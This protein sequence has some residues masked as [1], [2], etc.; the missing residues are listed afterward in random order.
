MSAGIAVLVG[1]GLR[2][3]RRVGVLATSIVLVLAAIAIAAGLVVSRQGAPLLDEAADEANVA[4]LVLYGDPVAITA[5]AADPAVTAWSGPFAAQGGIELVR[6]GETVPIEATALDSPDIAVNRPPARAG[7]WAASADEIV[8]DHSV[9]DDLGIGVGER[10]TLRHTGRDVEFAVVGTAVNFTDC[11]YPQCE[12]GRTWVTAAGLDRFDASDGGYAVGYLRFADPAAADPFVERQ[13]AAGIGGITGTDSWL[14]TRGDFLVLDRVFGSFVAAFGV[15]V[16]IVAAVVIAGSTAMR[17]VSQR[18]AIALLGAIGATPRQITAALLAENLVIG[19][20]AAV[21]GWFVAG[22][23]ASSLQ[24]GIGRTLGPQ[25]PSW[26]LFGLVA[27]LLAIVA[28]L[29]AATLASARSAARRPVTDVLRD[30][31]PGRVSWIN[32]R[33]GRLPG[34]LS[35]LGAQEVAGQPVRGALAA[36]AIGVAVVG[37]LVSFG[38]IRGIDLVSSD[39]ARA[40]DPWDIALVPGDSA[41]T[42]VEEVIAATPGAAAWFDEVARRSTFR[43]GAFLSVA[44]GGD[45]AAADYRIA[46]G[47]ALQGPGEAIVGYGFMQR[48]DVEVGDRVEFLAGT[49]PIEVEVVGWYR[50]TEDSGEIL[51]YR[52]EDLA[53]A[54][55]G[56]EPDLYR[57]T[58]QPGA[59]PVEVGS[60]VTGALGPDARFEVLDTGRADMEPLMV[61]LRLIAAVLLVTA[62]INLLST[63]LTSSRESAQGTGVALAI[64]FTPRQLVAQGAVAGAVLGVVATLVGVPLGLLVFR[65]LADL[66]SNGIGVGP[67]WLPTPG[68]VL[69][70]TVAAAAVFVSALLGALAVQRVARRPAADLVRGE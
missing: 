41:P 57:I 26:S 2:S 24:L 63:L 18:R 20:A 19:A 11:F 52:W 30:V 1:A 44:T 33:A 51:R 68:P 35:L 23:L 42:E 13:A 37:T 16:L 65:I 62:G 21:L 28:L 50:D 34:R 17:V 7:R 59:D 55:P 32:R 25:D 14:D 9:A 6:A 29:S 56:L 40:G 27:C 12:P 58:L 64:G 70:G 8:L 54:E 43:D 45:P 67:N 48:F 69:V 3:R 61:V 38:F 39:T 36:L 60:A 5:V 53:R 22:F 66:V 15:F 4:H 10:I 46:G 31:P 49:T 47:R